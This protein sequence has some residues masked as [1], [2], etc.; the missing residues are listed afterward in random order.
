M[1]NVYSQG[2]ATE[3]AFERF[4]LE[5]C[6][7]P[8]GGTASSYRTAMAKLKMVFERSLPSFART[9]DVWSITDPAELMR[10]YTDVKQEQDRFKNNQTGIFA[11]FAGKGDSYYRKGW[12][13]AALK[14]FAQF[15]A[16]EGYEAKFD[17]VLNASENGAKVSCESEKIISKAKIDWCLPEDVDP[18]SSQG[19]EAI[20]QTKTRIGQ[21]TFRKWV[22]S[23]YGGKCCV[24]GLDVPDVLRA[25]HI[26]AWADDKDNRMNPSN[27][28]CLSATYDAAFDKHLITFDDSYRMVLSKTLRDYCTAEVHRDYFLN[29][30]GKM[31]SMP[32]RFAPDIELLHKHQERLAS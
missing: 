20:R 14:F 16:T 25:S 27:G 17:D 31:I 18:N 28:L 22:L 13:S 29:F 6:G 12:C 24:T 21:Q 8:N 32:S 11:P 3:K 1:R 9:A 7:N 30:E 19:K 23:I 5:N 15:R 2:S 4:V 10:L 26:V